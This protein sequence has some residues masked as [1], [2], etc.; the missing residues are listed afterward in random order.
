MSQKRIFNNIFI[1][2]NGKVGTALKNFFT[3]NNITFFD[4]DK[5]LIQ[6]KDVVFL[7][8]KDESINIFIQEIKNINC[9]IFHFAGSKPFL[10][11]A[12]LIHP[13]ASI[14][15]KTD[16]SKI[17]F[18]ILKSTN[19]QAKKILKQLKFKFIENE[20]NSIGYHTS[21]VISGNFSQF[22]Y[23][24]ATEILLKLNFS[25]TDANNLVKQLME[26]S[27]ENIADLGKKGLSGPA[28]R[29]DLKTI[30]K[31]T[32]YLKTISKDYAEIYNLISKEIIKIGNN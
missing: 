6:N 17:T 31:E 22:F 19:K 9:Q 23:I 30:E 5:S 25:Q 12:T 21:A 16:L 18:I 27:L 7:A 2:G 15:Q 32:K 3:K 4:Y 8:I 11:N 29:N 13:F 10:K 1:K 20:I 24:V 14:S 28:I 26:T